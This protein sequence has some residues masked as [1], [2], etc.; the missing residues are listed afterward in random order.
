MARARR[1]ERGSIKRDF[2]MKHEELVADLES[3]DYDDYFRDME[4]DVF[5]STLLF[6]LNSGCH[7]FDQHKEFQKGGGDC[8][9]GGKVDV[10]KMVKEVKAERL[11]DAEHETLMKRFRTA[12]S[13]VEGNLLSCGACG[14]RVLERSVDPEIRFVRLS[15]SDERAKLLKFEERTAASKLECRKGIPSVVIPVDGVGGV[16]TVEPWKLFS[17]CESL[18][19]GPCHLHQELVDKDANGNESTL[20]CPHCWSALDKGRVPAFSVAN[21][22]DF[23]CCHRLGLT[24][25]NLHELVTLSRVRL[26]L[27]TVKIA[28]NQSG[29]VNLDRSR[30][31]C[32]AVLFSQDGPEVAAKLFSGEE[33]FDEDRLK[34]TIK[35]HL[36]DAEGRFDAL[37]Q[38][39]FGRCDI[40]ARPWVI[41]Q[42]LVILNKVHSSYGHIQVPSYEVIRSKIETANGYM[43][44]SATLTSAKGAIAHE[45][46]IGSDVSHAQSS[47][48]PCGSR[49]VHGNEPGD[50]SGTPDEEVDT[51]MRYT[52][53]TTKPDAVLHEGRLASLTCMR[54]FE[55]LVRDKESGCDVKKEDVVEDGVCDEEGAFEHVPD[56]DVKVVS[57]DLE[58]MKESGD[59]KTIRRGDY[60]LHDFASDDFGFCSCFS[61]VFM[62]GRAC[63]KSVGKLN[64]AEL[65]HLLGQFH[66]VPALER[67]LL[68]YVFDVQKRFRAMC[69]V[70][71]HIKNNDDAMAAMTLLLE[72][73]EEKDKLH[74]A[75][76]D[77]ESDLFK[78]MKAKCLCH[79]RFMGSDMSYGYNESNKVA[80][81]TTEL[82]KRKSTPTAFVTF[83]FNDI[84][85]PRAIRAAFRTVDNTK[86]PAVFEDGSSY[87]NS[88]EAFMDKIMKASV[89]VS[90]G[91]VVGPGL[92]RGERAAAAMKDPVAFVA[93]S[94]SLIHDVCAILFGIPPEGFFAKH[95]GVS[96][97]KTR[98]FK[99]SK[100]LFGHCLAYIGVVEDHAKGTLHCHLLVC[101][102]LSAYALQRFAALGD[103]CK[104]ISKALDDMHCSSLPAENHFSTALQS[105]I[106]SP[107]PHGFVKDD[108]NPINLD[109]ILDRLHRVGVNLTLCSLAQVTAKQAM[110]QQM[111]RHVSTCHHGFLGI[112]GCRF[113]IDAGHCPRTWPVRLVSKRGKKTR[114]ANC[115]GE[116][117]ADEDDVMEE[118]EGC[119]GGEGIGADASAAEGGGGTGAADDDDV[120]HTVKP[121]KQVFQMC[122]HRRNPLDKVREESVVVWETKR[123]FIGDCEFGGLSV[124]CQFVH[125]CLTRFFKCCVVTLS[126]VGTLL[127][128]K[129]LG[130]CRCYD[131]GAIAGQ[132]ED[133]VGARLFGLQRIFL[134]G[135]GGP[136]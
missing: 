6:Y 83:S 1:V 87:G 74:K 40:L 113:C 46:S 22:V 93:E 29:R 8:E 102:G 104:E 129:R 119:L 128:L 76:L 49:G 110:L 136:R 53:V 19:H 95:S 97:R 33:M 122:V 3:H 84:G 56:D 68:G 79:L 132:V 31:K 89:L 27:V 90:E 85:N 18:E 7:Q 43:R 72:S 100:G 58:S 73:K 48:L 124:S 71:S 77:P 51:S 10:E 67:R 94:K 133:G 64:Y 50:S 91:D 14:F 82:T 16:K 117:M 47:E 99:C 42:W 118:W 107:N 28:S 88:A 126:L 15:L 52:F 54:S 25:P 57:G 26:H 125:R 106:R 63:H 20:I 75:I 98:Y 109:P 55:K 23:G 41:Y 66:R 5:K 38:E 12:H 39:A 62:F 60:P 105:V 101:G 92:S 69:S 65:E 4:D 36:L 45:N 2:S 130:R 112:T 59:T 13:C 44:A 81:M 24:M 96:S 9:N 17:M 108:L 135:C 127:L 34:S 61:T 80:S 37:A 70:N 103:V 78:E 11:S 120:A 131:I 21:D 114:S 123:P 116:E 30:L 32:N 115:N 35:M 134:G 121:I 86:F 111:H